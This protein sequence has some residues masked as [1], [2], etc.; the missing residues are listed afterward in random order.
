MIRK[1]MPQTDSARKSSRYTIGEL[2][3]NLKKQNGPAGESSQS[4]GKYKIQKVLSSRP[5]SAVLLALDPDLR[6]Q[7]VLKVYKPGLPHD[8]ES[9]ILNEGQALAQIDCRHVA[10]CIAVESF[11]DCPCLVMEYISGTPLDKLKLPLKSAAALE[12][13]RQIAMAMQAV[14]Q[15]G[16]LHLDLKPS[17]VMLTD[18]G[19]VKLIDFG[20]A[21]PMS[22]V[23]FGE[24]SGT[25]SFMAPEVA[26]HEYARIDRRADVFGVGAVLYCLLTAEPPFQGENVDEVFKAA[27]L[28]QVTPPAVA[29]AGIS[30][31]AST[32]CSRCLSRNPADRY[33]DMET[34]QSGLPRFEPP[35]RQVW[36]AAA[37]GVLVCAIA[38]FGW[39]MLFQPASP[40]LAQVLVELGSN[41]ERIPALPGGFGLKL[42]N[43]DLQPGI[44]N[45]VHPGDGVFLTIKPEI[46]S[47]IAVFSVEY[48]PEDPSSLI[49]DW[50][51][52]EQRFV[53]PGDV[54]QQR[55]EFNTLTPPGKKEFLV[56]AAR[57]KR[58]SPEETARRANDILN[59]R[60]SRG[61]S[62]S[63]ESFFESAMVIPYR[64]VNRSN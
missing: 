41:P 18:E 60:K 44:V 54:Y 1:D 17:N 5:H 16:L 27:Q 25:P 47:R 58:W 56:V 51:P 19:T 38:L 15:R 55:I 11:D 49:V 8:P 20:L 57:N 10:R 14:H 21:Q 43:N 23:R 48:R 3:L 37:I 7:V 31:H 12:I 34:L 28:G 42:V 62:G 6:R 2:F 53:S 35:R 22:N 33:P 24:V 9:L 13:I 63:A 64:V 4:F 32:I 61:A 39:T 30:Q 40:R 50:V 45:T 36:L 46:E 52:D 26:N 29:A 59:N